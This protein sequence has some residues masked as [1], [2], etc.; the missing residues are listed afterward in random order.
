MSQGVQLAH[1]VSEHTPPPLPAVP[2]G[3]PPA[4]PHGPGPSWKTRLCIIQLVRIFVLLVL[5]LVLLKH[6]LSL[7]DVAIFEPI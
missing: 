5:V 7:D 3:E 1:R 2:G 4:H 6:L